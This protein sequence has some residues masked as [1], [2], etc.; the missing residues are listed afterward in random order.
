M[1]LDI[2]F[3]KQAAIQAGLVVTTS[4]N[5][6][7]EEIRYARIKEQ[8]AGG[9]EGYANWLEQESSYIKVP[10]AD[11]STGIYEGWIV[12]PDGTKTLIFCARANRGGNTFA[13]LTEWLDAHSI[14][15]DES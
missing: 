4:R 7:D 8:D 14:E 9:W 15:W 2:C 5:G 13:P 3:N 6:T 11:H 1:D 12:E 10:G